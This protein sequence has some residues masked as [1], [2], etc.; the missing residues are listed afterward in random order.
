VA[1]GDGGDS[2]SITVGVDNFVRA[3]TDRMFAALQTDAGGVNVFRHNREPTSIEGQT[4]IRM[5]RDTLYSFAIVDIS[6]GATI[7]VPD[8]GGRYLSVMVVNQDHYINR[9]FHDPG[10][11]DLTDD[12][13][14][15]PWV[16]VAVRAL[17][18]P[19]DPADIALVTAIQDQVKLEANS[20][21]P[22]QMPDYEESSFDAT[23]K[24]VLELAKHLGNLDHAFGNRN[25]VNPVRHLLATAAGWGGLPD[26][27]ARYISVDPGGVSGDHKLTVRDVPVDGFWSISV[28]NTDGFFEPND[29]DAYSV[30]NITATPNA[31]GSITVH[32][33]GCGDAR[34]NCLP[35]THGWNFI[36]RLYRPRPEILDGS[37][38]FPSIEPA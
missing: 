3:E 16:L 4:V 2:V 11:Y 35:I 7:T 19:A 33:G 23:R 37:W 15:T 17:V 29:R 31:D 36:I 27:E 25:E 5:N 10:E 12:E 20:S 38:A 30:N 8:S 18:D 14:E 1:D 26:R 34:P 21:K 13:F 28:Y 22:F 6:E 9:L 32:F 24:A